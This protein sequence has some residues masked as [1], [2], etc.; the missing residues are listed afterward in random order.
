MRYSLLRR[1]ALL[2]A[3]ASQLHAQLPGVSYVISG[4]IAT[5]SGQPVPGVSVGRTSGT[6]AVSDASGRYILGVPSN[7]SGTITPTLSGYTFSPSSYSYSSISA[8][9]ANQDFTA[10]ATAS[11]P[12]LSVVGGPLSFTYQVGSAA[13]N[14]QT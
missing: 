7:F 2:I 12:I 3:W 11:M 13:P 14:S 10:T 6:P 5:S 4:R 8:D 1:S 9:Q